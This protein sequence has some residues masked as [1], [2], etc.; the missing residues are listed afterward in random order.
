MVSRLLK[1]RVDT[2]VHVPECCSQHGRRDYNGF[3][4]NIYFLVFSIEKFVSKHPT[5]STRSQDDVRQSHVWRQGLLGFCLENP[6]YKQTISF[7]DRIERVTR[8]PVLLKATE[9]YLSLY[10]LIHKFVET[11]KVNTCVDGH[12]EENGAKYAGAR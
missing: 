11:V 10:Q 5:L 12:A 4:G 6:V 2:T 9:Y 8:C 3:V 7:K 1:T